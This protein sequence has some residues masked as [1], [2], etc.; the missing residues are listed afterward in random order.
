M[1]P[2]ESAAGAQST[3]KRSSGS[4]RVRRDGDVDDE[5]ALVCNAALR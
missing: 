4:V 2:G 5:D 1:L 3:L